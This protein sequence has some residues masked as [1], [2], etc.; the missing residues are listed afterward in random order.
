MTTP[1]PGRPFPLGVTWEGSGVNV[2]VYSEGA[3][4]VEFC[5]FDAAGDESRVR[6]PESTGFIHHGYLPDVEPGTRYG[7]RAH[8]PWSPQEG[9]RFNASKLLVDPY[10]RAITGDLMWDDAVFGH[11][12]HDPSSINPA[13]SARY[14]PRAVVV[15]GSFDWGDD[16]PPGTPLHETL[17]YEAHVKGLTMRHP[18]VPPEL[19][20][21]YAGIAS[22]PV[23]EHLLSIGV[24]AIE[25][26][27][28]HHFVSEH[29][30]V[31]KGLSNYWGYNSIGYFAPHAAYGSAVGADE[32]LTEFKQMVRDLH[33]AD[34]EVIL[35]VVYN[36]TAEGNHLGPTLSLK[37]L[38]NRAYYR[39]AEDDRARYV[40]YTGTGNSLDVR[41]P[42]SLRLIMDSLRYWI[43][44]MHVD[45]FR[46][47]LAATLAR[48][49]HEVDRL[50]PFLNL[51]HQD[52]VVS[53]VKL[54][55]EPWDVG[56][57]GYHVGNFPP[58]WSEWNGRFRDGVRD[59]WRGADES[60]G[61]FG[62]RFTGS[63]DL[64][65]W[66]GRK[67]SA[68][69]NFITAHDGFAL[70]DLVTYEER[71]NEANGEDNQD[72]ERHN[73]SWNSGVEGATD[74]LDVLAVRAVR[75]R[76]MLATLFL[77]QGV[78]MLVAGD[79]LGRTQLGNNNAYCQDGPLSW[80]D[81]NDA[82]QDLLA[83]VR[84]L[85]EVRGENPVF[86]KRRWFQGRALHGEG[87]ED[88]RWYTP[89][90]AEMTETDWDA[91]YARSLGVFLNG[92]ST[93]NEGQGFLLLFN[94]SPEPVGFVLPEPHGASRWNIVLD[95]SIPRGE[96]E[97]GV[98]ADKLD[99]AAWSTVLLEADSTRVP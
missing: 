71:N 76:S 84:R 21:T 99:V 35:D 39:L 67:P 20:G 77:S 29:A 69:I 14:M 63:S 25:L 49:H 93:E 4:S 30:L 3:S 95:S 40:D 18:D 96:S 89:D 12:P 17:I 46:F 59:Y 68:S 52:P 9:L 82:D 85:S 58:L 79:E 64:Y 90:G 66:S 78:P 54:I 15:D 6:L 70:A 60:L 26:L 61:D 87:V 2:A 88:I 1:T 50:S 36:H 33:S 32:L 72:G 34:I 31:K 10:A 55:A 81:W 23:I 98:P 47:D 51:V 83:F 44:E 19:R 24:T 16:R 75:V 80:I 97:V 56:E 94:A 92:S 42:E 7:L 57:D 74:D 41:H 73:R 28:V 11:L 62:Y 48:G 22:P 27:P 43:E 5:I 38:D 53:R 45:G 65:E 86:R 91:G 37:G 13:D 8:G